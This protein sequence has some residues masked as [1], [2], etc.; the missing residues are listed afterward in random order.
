MA[1]IHPRP[2][3]AIVRHPTYPILVPFPVVCFTLTLLTDI[4]YWQTSNLMWLHFSEW[5]LF[6]GIVVGVVA[7]LVG[8]TE[9]LVRPGIRAQWPGWPN[10]IGN[11]I[12]L[13]LA[14]INNL[15]HTGDGWTGVIPYGLILSAAT[16]LLM[17]VTGW[18][19]GST[20]YRYAVGA[21]DH[22]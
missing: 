19:G 20:V 9:F 11:L 1:H 16:V 15:V 6:A 7:F 8:L 5:L 2:S 12:V 22:D 3:V 14:L 4:A 13:V 17:L 18:L 10:A 21:R